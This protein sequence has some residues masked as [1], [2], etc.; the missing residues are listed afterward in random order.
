MPTTAVRNAVADRFADDGPRWLHVDDALV[1]ACK[2]PGLLAV[3]GRGAAGARHLAGMAQARW[4]DALVVHRLDMSTSGLVVF[5]RGPA[6]QRALGD[7]F[8]ERRVRKRYVAVV[9]GDIAGEA[10]EIDLPLAADWPNRPR[11]IVDL[12]RGKPA[13]T[14]WRVLQRLPGAT[15]VELEPVT[16]RTHQLRVHLLAAGHP[17]R[18]DALYAA[19][20]LG[21]GRLL[22]HAAGLA[23]PHPTS[24][25]TVAFSSEPEF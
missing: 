15:R 2:P 19:P 3:P 21:S 8:A 25:D 11:Q 12:A 1:V 17:I 22:L 18:G 10:G 5:G 20:P 13:L 14:R 7:A 6:A 9:E 4:P 16:G 23:L 24:G